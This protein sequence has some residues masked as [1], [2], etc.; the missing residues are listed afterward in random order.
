V[1]AL[2]LAT[3]CIAVLSARAALA[4]CSEPPQP[5]EAW[6][7]TYHDVATR[8]LVDYDTTFALTA[9][10]KVFVDSD[11]VVTVSI[12]DNLWPAWGDRQV[13]SGWWVEDTPLPAGATVPLDNG[14]AVIAFDGQ[15]VT[16]VA[17]VY[18]GVPVDHTIALRFLPG[19]SA[20]GWNPAWIASLT[21]DPYPP[22]A[23]PPPGDSGSGDPPAADPSAP[24]A[25]ETAGGCSTAGTNLATLALLG[26]V[27]AMLRR[28]RAP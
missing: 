13:A 15:W 16:T 1:K 10:C 7:V 19:I 4:Q 12:T 14:T 5:D 24:A 2:R 25:P 18:H 20:M 28:R 3:A 17:N 26:V 11:F 22:P 8:S 27:A 23:A 21:V 9:P 6:T